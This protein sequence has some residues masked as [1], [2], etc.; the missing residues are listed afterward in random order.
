MAD[1]AYTDISHSEYGFE[2]KLGRVEKQVWLHR[3][4]ATSL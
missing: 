3:F 4:T 2:E 1:V